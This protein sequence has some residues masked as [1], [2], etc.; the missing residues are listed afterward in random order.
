MGDL[1]LFVVAFSPPQAKEM[2]ALFTLQLFYIV[3]R[4]VKLKFE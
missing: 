3:C 4:R 2:H 1:A